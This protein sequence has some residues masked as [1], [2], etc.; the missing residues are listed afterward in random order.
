MVTARSHRRHAERP[1]QPSEHEERRR[2]QSQLDHF[3]VVEHAA[4]AGHERIV[5]PGV[6]GGQTPGEVEREALTLARRLL[7][8]ELRQQV[9]V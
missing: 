5:D 4:Q 6:I 9:V 8:V 2:D 3:G 1:V 7:A